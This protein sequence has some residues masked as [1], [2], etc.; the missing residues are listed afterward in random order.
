[1][2]EIMK[3]AETD[4]L[5]LHIQTSHRHYEA[6]KNI[7]AILKYLSE[8]YGVH[9]L[10]LEG[11]WDKLEPELLRLTPEDE[12]TN[13][14]ITDALLKAGEITGAEAFLIDNESPADGW[15]IEDYEAYAANGAVFKEIIRQEPLIEKGLTQVKAAWEKEAAKYFSKQLRDFI[16]REEAFLA[17]Q[18]SM[19]DWLDHLTQ[20]AR[21]CLHLDLENVWH[22]ATWP[23]LVRYARLKKVGELFNEEKIREESE[24]FIIALRRLQISEEIVKSIQ[25][26][27]GSEL[28]Q[29]N[30]AQAR[31]ILRSRTQDGEEIPASAT[32]FL[33]ERLFD[34]LPEDFSMELFPNLKL[35]IQQLVLISELEGEKLEEETLRLTS[36][37]TEALADGERDKE[38]V[39]MLEA[40]RHFE[41]LF[42]LELTRKEYLNAFTSRGEDPFNR[43]WE[44]IFSGQKL[45]AKDKALK[46][47]LQ[48]LYAKAVQFYE[49][50]VRR[51]KWMAEN[52]LSHLRQLENRKAVLITGGFHA[53]GLKDAILNQ[54]VSYVQ[55]TPRVTDIPQNTRE[56]Y[57]QM[58]LGEYLP[59]NSK[60]EAALRL[61]MQDWPGMESDSWPGPSQQNVAR[62]ML[63]I[64]GLQ[65]NG[66]AELDRQLKTSRLAQLAGL[67][68]ERRTV[69][70][71]D[72]NPPNRW[73]GHRWDDWDA[74]HLVQTVQSDTAGNY[75]I[76]ID[77][78]E[79]I[80]RLVRQIQGP[81]QPN[82]RLVVEA[83]K[84]GHALTIEEAV[85][86]SHFSNR[87][88][89]TGTVDL[90]KWRDQIV[91][92]SKDKKGKVKPLSREEAFQILKQIAEIR[93]MNA[94]TR[95]LPMPLLIDA[96]FAFG[97][98]KKLREMLFDV[99][100]DYVP[101]PTG[102][103]ASR[104]GSNQ[105]AAVQMNLS[106][107]I[108][109]AKGEN[110]KV[111][112]WDW[113]FKALDRY[114]EQHRIHVSAARQRKTKS[115]LRLSPTETSTAR[116]SMQPPSGT[117]SSTGV[118]P[119]HEVQVGPSRS[120]PHQFPTEIGTAQSFGPT[121]QRAELREV[122]SA[123]LL[124]AASV[125]VIG[126]DIS[127]RIQLRR[128]V[129][130]IWEGHVK[131]E[132]SDPD[133]F[134]GPGANEMFFVNESRKWTRRLV[135]AI[136]STTHDWKAS[137]VSLDELLSRI[138]QVSVSLI[139]RNRRSGKNEHWYITVPDSVELKRLA[140]DSSRLRSIIISHSEL[141]TE[142]EYFRQL[143]DEHLEGIR[144][145][146]EKFEERL[147]SIAGQHG[148]DKLGL[149]YAV[150]LDVMRYN[151]LF[152]GDILE[153]PGYSGLSRDDRAFLF[154]IILTIWQMVYD[155]IRQLWTE[156]SRESN[157]FERLAQVLDETGEFRAALRVNHQEALN[158]VIHAL[159]NSG[160]V[161]GSGKQTASDWVDYIIASA[162]RFEEGR[163][164]DMNQTRENILLLK[165]LFDAKF[166]YYHQLNRYR[167]KS[168][169]RTGGRVSI[170]AFVEALL[171]HDGEF[172]RA[173]D[174]DDQP[175]RSELR[176]L[177][178]EWGL[179]LGAVVLG[180]VFYA[181]NVYLKRAEFFERVE[182]I[183][184]E[185]IRGVLKE[186]HH[187]VEPGHEDQ[188][189][190]DSWVDR[191][192][193]R[194]LL[195]EL[196]GV[197]RKKFRNDP[198]A[199][200]I[201]NR[202][203]RQ[204]SDY[205][206]PIVMREGDR[207]PLYHFN[208][209]D[210]RQLKIMLEQP[211]RLNEWILN[212]KSNF[213]PDEIE[214]T[215]FQRS[216]LRTGDIVFHAEPSPLLPAIEKFYGQFQQT[217]GWMLEGQLSGV[218]EHRLVRDMLTD[219]AQF[220]QSERKWLRGGDFKKLTSEEEAFL[221]FSYLL[222]LWRIIHQELE[223]V[224][225]EYEKGKQPVS[226]F[227]AYLTQTP[228]EISGR[229]W[230]RHREPFGRAV[231]LIGQH[232][233]I[234]WADDRRLGADFIDRV[235]DRL[236]QS[237]AGVVQ[238]LEQENNRYAAMAI[239]NYLFRSRQ[240][241]YKEFSDY[242][243]DY[244]KKNL[245]S[246]RPRHVNE[247]RNLFYQALEQYEDTL[248]RS[249]LRKGVRSKT[250]V[251]GELRE[252]ETA[253]NGISRALSD[254][255][256]GLD[257]EIAN[258]TLTELN[259]QKDR[260]L[261][262][263]RDLESRS[264]LRHD[265]VLEW[266]MT[267]PNRDFNQ[268][269]T[270]FTFYAARQY[271]DG[272]A[273]LMTSPSMMGIQYKR[274]QSYD[275][276]L[277]RHNPQ[278]N[279]L[280]VVGKTSRIDEP[281]AVLKYVQI[282]FSDEDLRVYQGQAG[283][284]HGEVA[285]GS[286]EETRI[287]AEPLN[288]IRY[289][290][291]RFELVVSPQAFSFLKA[292][293]VMITGLTYVEKT[294]ETEIRP[295]SELHESISPVLGWGGTV[296]ILLGAGLFLVTLGGLAA[297]FLFRRWKANG[298]YD[299][300][301]GVK[302][303]VLAAVK[304]DLRVDFSSGKREM[305]EE[306][307][308]GDVIDIDYD[309][310]FSIDWAALP[311][312]LLQDL[313]RQLAE[314]RRPKI[315]F[316]SGGPH[317]IVNHV[318]HRFSMNRGKR[319]P[320]RVIAK[321]T[322]EIR[323][324]RSELRA[325]SVS[326]RDFFGEAFGDWD[327]LVQ[328]IQRSE[329]TYAAIKP[330][331]HFPE[332]VQL[333]IRY[334][335]IRTFV[336]A[337]FLVHIGRPIRLTREEAEKF[338]TV[339]QGKPFFDA[340]VDYVSSDVYVPLL[341]EKKDG[342]E[343][344]DHAR[345]TIVEIRRKAQ[346][347][348]LVRGAELIPQG[349]ETR[350]Y[351]QNLIH[352]SD[353]PE[354]AIYEVGVILS[355]EGARS[356]MRGMTDHV[357]RT[358]DREN[359]LLTPTL[360]PAGRRQ[361]EGAIHLGHGS[362]DLGLERSE[363]RTPS[364]A[365]WSLAD[366]EFPRG[367]VILTDNYIRS[368]MKTYSLP[369]H[370]K[371]AVLERQ[372]GDHL[373]YAGK[374]VT[375]I[376][377][378]ELVNEVNIISLQTS[379]SV[380]QTLENLL[381][382][383]E[384][385]LV[386]VP[387]SSGWPENEVASWIHDYV[388]VRGSPL[389]VLLYP[390]PLEKNDQFFYTPILEYDFEK[391][392]LPAVKVH[393]TQNRRTQY[394][395]AVRH[396]LRF[397][398][399]RA[400]AERRDGPLS[401]PVA[402]AF[403]VELIRKGE[404]QRVLS[405][406]NQMAELDK[407][408]PLIVISPHPDDDVI[409]A[410]GLIRNILATTGVENW[411]LGRGYTGVTGV[412]DLTPEE[413]AWGMRELQQIFKPG[414]D[415]Y[416]KTGF[417]PDLYGRVLK[418]T[419]ESPS[420]EV[421]SIVEYQVD[422]LG[423][424]PAVQVKINQWELGDNVQPVFGELVKRI[425]RRKEVEE[426]S[427]I[428]SRDLERHVSVRWFD[429]HSV[430][431]PHGL[432]P[433]VPDWMV[434]Q[435]EVVILEE[436]QHFFNEHR[437]QIMASQ[438]HGVPWSIV[439]PHPEDQHPHHK[440]TSQIV[441]TVLQDL[442][443]REG[444]EIQ[445]I[446]YQ[447]PWAGGFDTY[448]VTDTEIPSEA[449][450]P[451]SGL[452]R[453][454]E[455]SAME[456]YQRALTFLVGELAGRSFGLS[457]PTPEQL[458]GRFT[459]SFKRLVFE[460]VRSELRND[461]QKRAGDLLN[462]LEGFDTAVQTAFKAVAKDVQKIDE[463]G[464]RFQVTLGGFLGSL[465][466]VKDLLRAEDLDR[467]VFL[468]AH[469]ALEKIQSGMKELIGGYNPKR[470]SLGEVRTAGNQLDGIIK[471]LAAF[472]GV[473]K[474]P[475]AKT[476]Q[477]KTEP[478][479]E[480]VEGTVTPRESH[481]PSI[482]VKKHQGVDG[483]GAVSAPPAEFFELASGL[484]QSVLSEML[485]DPEINAIGKVKGPAAEL[486][487]VKG[488]IIWV[489]LGSEPETVAKLVINGLR[490]GKED[491]LPV[492]YGFLIVSYRAA[493]G[494]P[495]AKMIV[496]VPETVPA[497][498][499]RS[500]RRV[501][502]E[503]LNR[504]LREHKALD[505]IVVALHHS[506]RVRA[507]WVNAPAGSNVKGYYVFLSQPADWDEGLEERSAPV[508]MY[509][510]TEGEMQQYEWEIQ[511]LMDESWT[512]Q[513]RKGV[514]LPSDYFL[515][516]KKKKKVDLAL[517]SEDVFKKAAKAMA[518]FT[519]HHQI[520]M[521]IRAA[522][523]SELGDF[524]YGAEIKPSQ[525]SDFG[526]PASQAPQNMI[527][528]LQYVKDHQYEILVGVQDIDRSMGRIRLVL[529]GSDEKIGSVEEDVKTDLPGLS[530]QKAKVIKEYPSGGRQVQLGRKVVI[531]RDFHQLN[532][533]YQIL[534]KRFR[535]E[536]WKGDYLVSVAEIERALDQMQGARGKGQGRSE[537][538]DDNQYVARGNGTIRLVPSEGNKAEIHIVQN[539]V[540]QF[541]FEMMS[542]S[543]Q[544]VVDSILSGIGSQAIEAV[545]IGSSGHLMVSVGDFNR[546][547]VDPVLGTVEFKR[548]YV[549][550]ASGVIDL[551]VE[552]RHLDHLA[553]T[554]NGGQ[555]FTH[556]V[557]SAVITLTAIESVKGESGYDAV[558]QDANGNLIIL[559]T[560]GYRVRVDATTDE[561]SAMPATGLD[562]LQPLKEM[563]P[564]Q[565]GTSEWEGEGEQFLVTSRQGEI[566]I[567]TTDSIF[568]V[569]VNLNGK[570]EFGWAFAKPAAQVVDE[571][572]DV[573]AQFGSP[574]G[575][576][577]VW[578]DKRNRDLVIELDDGRMI[579]VKDQSGEIW[580]RRADAGEGTIVLESTGNYGV[581]V[582]LDGNYR[583]E[584]EYQ[585]GARRSAES[586]REHQGTS[587]IASVWSNLD[588]GVHIFYLDDG[589]MLTAD[590]QTSEVTVTGVKTAGEARPADSVL[591]KLPPGAEKVVDNENGF[592]VL[593]VSRYGNILVYAGNRDRAYEIPTAKDTGHAYREVH[594]LQR[595]A[596]ISSIWKNPET[597]DHFIVLSDGRVIQMNYA[598]HEVTFMSADTAP[599]NLPGA[600]KIADSN[601]G[602]IMLSAASTAL[603]LLVNDA[604]KE[605]F[606]IVNPLIVAQTFNSLR[607]GSSIK[608]VWGT[609]EELFF[610]LD[611]KRVIVIV[612][613][614][615]NIYVEGEEPVS[616]SS[617]AVKE[618]PNADKVADWGNG[619]IALRRNILDE[620]MVYEGDRRV[621]IVHIPSSSSEQVWNQIRRLRA[622][623]EIVAVWR[624][625][626]SLD[627]LIDLSDGR[628][629]RI[630]DETGRIGVEGGDAT[631]PAPAALVP[632][633]SSF[634]PQEAVLVVDST[635]GG[636]ALEV[637][638]DGDI[639]IYIGG[640]VD[641][642]RRIDNTTL[643][644]AKEIIEKLGDHTITAIWLK[645]SESNYYLDKAYYFVLDNGQTVVFNGRT[646]EVSI[647]GVG[648][649]PAGADVTAKEHPGS[650]RVADQKNGEI[651]IRWDTDDQLEVLEGRSLAHTIFLHDFVADRVLSQIQGLQGSSRVV[652]VWEEIST[653]DTLIDLSDGR[654]LRINEINSR[655][656]VEGEPVVASA[657]RAGSSQLA[658]ASADEMLEMEQEAID[659]KSKAEPVAFQ[660]T[661]DEI[662]ERGV[663]VVL[664]GE[665]RSEV[666]G[667]IF[668]DQLD[669]DLS[670]YW[671]GNT[672]SPVYLVSYKYR[673]PE[674]QR[675][676]ALFTMRY[677]RALRER[678]SGTRQRMTRP[679]ALEYVQ[680][681]FQNGTTVEAVVLGASSKG[682]GINFMIGGV[683]RAFMRDRYARPRSGE[684]KELH[685]VKVDV[686]SGDD[687]YVEL[688]E[689]DH[690]LRRGR[691]DYRRYMP[692]V[693]QE[694]AMS[695]L[696]D[697][698][699]RGTTVS[700]RAGRPNERRTGL[701]GT[702][703][704]A[705]HVFYRDAQAAA[706]W[707]RQTPEQD[708][709]G[710]YVVQKVE[711]GPDSFYILQRNRPSASGPRSQRSMGRSGSGG[712]FTSSGPAGLSPYRRKGGRTP[713]KSKRPG[714]GGLDGGR[715]RSEL[716]IWKNG[717]LGE[718]QLEIYSTRAHWEGA[719]KMAVPREIILHSGRGE[720]VLLNLKAAG[721]A[722]DQ[723]SH[724]VLTYSMVAANSL[725]SLWEEGLQ[726]G[727]FKV[728]IDQEGRPVSQGI[729][730][731]IFSDVQ[732]Q[733]AYLG[734]S[735][736]QW[737]NAAT[738]GGEFPFTL[739]NSRFVTFLTTNV[740][741]T[742]N[743]LEQP[744]QGND[745]VVDHVS[746]VNYA[747]D[748]VRK[749]AE[750]VLVHSATGGFGARGMTPALAQSIIESETRA[751][752]EVGL[753]VYANV[754]PTRSRGY[755]EDYEKNKGE[756][757]QEML[758]NAGIAENAG[759]DALV[760]APLTFLRSS[761]EITEVVNLLVEATDLPVVFYDNPGL[762]LIPGR[763][764]DAA[765]VESLWRSG[766]IAAIKVSTD[767]FEI[768]EGYLRTGIRVYIGNE[769]LIARAMEKGA[770]GSV[771][772]T[773]NI[774]SLL[775]DLP[776]TRNLD[777]LQ[778]LQR[779]VDDLRGPLTVDQTK[780]TA[781]ILYVLA[782][783]GIVQ[784]VLL[785]GVPTL[786]DTEK[787][788]IDEALVKV[789]RLEAGK[790]AG[791]AQAALEKKVVDRFIEDPLGYVKWLRDEADDATLTLAINHIE[792]VLTVEGN[793]RILEKRGVLEEIETVLDEIF[794]AHEWPE[795]AF[796]VGEGVVDAAQADLQRARQILV[797]QVVRKLSDDRHAEMLNRFY[798]EGV[799]RSL[800]ANVA[801]AMAAVPRHLYASRFNGA[802]AYENDIVYIGR[803]QT[804]SQPSLIA[805][806]LL[807]LHL[808]GDEKVL[809]V[810][811]GSGWLASLLGQ[812]T[813]EVY[814]TEI[815]EL[816]RKRA[817]RTVQKMG[818]QNV[819]ILQARPDVLGYP[820]AGPYDVIVV[821]AGSS[822]ATVPDELANQLA[823]GGKLLIPLLDED[824]Q[825]LRERENAK[826][827]YSLKVFVKRNGVLVDIFDMKAMGYP[828]SFVPL[829]LPER[830]EL[831]AIN[832]KSE[833]SKSANQLVI[834][835]GGKKKSGRHMRTVPRSFTF[836]VWRDAAQLVNEIEAIAAT[837]NRHYTG[838]IINSERGHLV[839]Q[840]SEEATTL[841]TK[842]WHKDG[843]FSDLESGDLVIQLS[844]GASILVS[845]MDNYAME[846]PPA[847]MTREIKMRRRVKL[848]GLVPSILSVSA[849]GV[850]QGNL[851]VERSSS[852]I[853]R[854]IEG[855]I[856]EQF[857][858]GERFFVSAEVSPQEDVLELVLN[859]GQ[860]VVVTEDGKRVTIEE[861]GR[862]A[863]PF[864]LRSVVRLV[865]EWE[866]Y[867]QVQINAS[868]LAAEMGISSDLTVTDRD[869]VR[870]IHL[871]NQSG[872]EY[873]LVDLP[874]EIGSTF[875]ILPRSEY[876]KV[877]PPEDR[878]ELRSVT[879]HA[880]RTMDHGNLSLTP[881]LSPAG[882]ARLPAVGQ[883][884]GASDVV[885]GPWSVVQARS[886]LRRSGHHYETIQGNIWVNREMSEFPD[887]P[888]LSEFVISNGPE[889]NY[890]N[891]DANFR[892]RVLY[893][894]Y[895]RAIVQVKVPGGEWSEEIQLY[896]QTGRHA[897]SGTILMELRGFGK[898]E[899]PEFGF[900][901]P[902]ESRVLRRREFDR[903]VQRRSELR[904]DF[905][906]YVNEG[907]YTPNLKGWLKLGVDGKEGGLYEFSEFVISVE[908][909]LADFDD[910]DRNIR[911]QVTDF[912]KAE[913][914]VEFLWKYP[915]R[916]WSQPV[917]IRMESD[918]FHITRNAIIRFSSFDR[919][920]FPG[921]AFRDIKR[922]HEIL[923]RRAYEEIKTG[924]VV[925]YPGEEIDLKHPENN[926]HLEIADA[927]ADQGRAMIKYHSRGANRWTR[928][929][930]LK[931][932]AII[933]IDGLISVTYRGLDKEGKPQF[934]FEPDNVKVMPGLEYRQ[935]RQSAY[936]RS[937]SKSELRIEIPE[938]VEVIKDLIKET[939]GERQIRITNGI[940]ANRLNISESA[941][942]TLML[943]KAI[944]Q[945][946]E[947]DGTHFLEPI[948]TEIGHTYLVET[949]SELRGEWFNLS[950]D[951]RNGRA[952]ENYSE[953][954]ISTT[955]R[956]DVTDVD[957]NIRVE[958][959]ESDWQREWV[960]IRVKLPGGEWS[961]AITLFRG[962][963]YP[964]TKSVD[965]Q[966]F[967]FNGSRE[968][969]LGVTRLP[970]VGV[971]R[972]RLF[973]RDHRRWLEQQPAVRIRAELRLSPTETNTARASAQSPGGTSSS[974][975]VVPAHE[976]QVTMP[977]SELRSRNW[978]NLPLDV[979]KGNP[980]MGE[981]VLSMPV[982]DM[983]G[984]TM[985][986][987]RVDNN[988]RLQITAFSMKGAWIEFRYKLPG[989]HAKWSKNYR[990]QMGDGLYP[991]TESVE[992]ELGSFTEEG[993]PVI[994][995][996]APRSVRI[997]TRQNYDTSN[998]QKTVW[999]TLRADT[1000]AGNLTED[1001][1002][1003][1004]VINKEGEVDQTD[1005]NNN[1006][1007]VQVIDKDVKKQ[1008]VTITV[1009]Y[1010]GE[1011]KIRT[1012]LLRRHEEYPVF[1013]NFSIRFHYFDDDGTPYFDF[1014]KD[1015]GYKVLRRS[1016]YGRGP[1017]VQHS[1018]L[1019]EKRV[1020]LQG[1021]QGMPELV[1022]SFLPED[1023]QNAV[1024]GYREIGRVGETGIFA[1025][1026]VKVMD[1027]I[1028]PL[1029]LHGLAA[1030]G[1031]FFTELLS[1032]NGL[1033][1034]AAPGQESPV[1035][1036]TQA[1037][1038]QALG[1039]EKRM[1040]D[1041]I[1042][1043]GPDAAF[1044]LAMLPAVRAVYAGVPLF[1045]VGADTRQ[1046]E[1047]LGQFNLD[1048][1049]QSA[1050]AEVRLIDDVSQIR[1051]ELL[1052]KIGD[1053]N[1054][1055]A[1056]SLHLTA[1057]LT[1058]RDSMMLAES[1059]KDQIPNTIF[1060]T[1061]RMAEHFRAQAGAYV[1062]SLVAEFQA[1063]Y[1064]VT[1065]SA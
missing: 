473:T 604:V 451:D 877:V 38:L 698:L 166:H 961:E 463:E 41:K 674:H 927:D 367:G 327:N 958:V 724:N 669:Q 711:K 88:N 148:I 131:R 995:F 153:G 996:F 61:Q 696:E 307:M 399:A 771:G 557:K 883:G 726:V 68:S 8:R 205:T 164:G 740:L 835:V 728:E 457:S 964:L 272:S 967:T 125:F 44:E 825:A 84:S 767:Q 973:N 678:Q 363:S 908:G 129:T 553:V 460:P 488:S 50:A 653:L 254:P 710:L 528:L 428:L 5:I 580:V 199:I 946:N 142:D 922:K 441:M 938:I 368:D 826:R 704:G 983:P 589:R 842:G 715:R 584:L 643:S 739:Q 193:S 993:I 1017:V 847:G 499:P 848:N 855:L 658:A 151:T 347:S 311:T 844:D 849:E 353:S 54:G 697:A 417:V 89:G 907:Q 516:R 239:L 1060:V 1018:E 62:H 1014:T 487:K 1042:V 634:I 861:G 378:A 622:S 184:V 846:I 158:L 349:V 984:S 936:R 882:R 357:Q 1005:I 485:L 565:T 258:R 336:Q 587:R 270:D 796:Q 113:G 436:F 343:I 262:E 267:D 37:I 917:K 354:N 96:F 426:A 916:G 93:L 920:G 218:K 431:F 567:E 465:E 569:A 285:S 208:L 997:F 662:R 138:P 85:E 827:L 289:Q 402:N 628:T 156:L 226:G 921:F 680:D 811:G 513:E 181:L 738:N 1007:R 1002:S 139:R 381:S 332:E 49:G 977:R 127:W 618:H 881:T 699:Q 978:V 550:A 36:W 633:A 338:Y 788:A 843:I 902:G 579:R 333:A 241:F 865:E 854:E 362:W 554:V 959:V 519:S 694:T 522:V 750:A 717:A 282:V 171:R 19:S 575:Y 222:P 918:E 570:S 211:A 496:L 871:Y 361:G 122:S 109:A 530:F 706:E 518:L 605:T 331:G 245:R 309:D 39:R 974:T 931:T 104:R 1026:A 806:I 481:R 174:R 1030:A 70:S 175:P 413:I 755:E 438:T 219:M 1049:R 369:H 731:E 671:W 111:I 45:K 539:D 372:E 792:G 319:L 474:K 443:R 188:I 899:R 971:L 681:A 511:H 167:D 617:T 477:P 850:V 13:L 253:I 940:V 998:R 795:E 220:H 919:E 236:V 529:G 65:L 506:Y 900:Y 213:A 250:T 1033:A 380:R 186:S 1064:R 306:K 987:S 520:V 911:I 379:G 914:W 562:E 484:K 723:P 666:K 702:Y 944:G 382:G 281:D 791:I 95:L 246:L 126:L 654:T 559:L 912:S 235:I 190:D 263:L 514:Y 80:L 756:A 64:A 259:T 12:E 665:D 291:G 295:R 1046:K 305:T 101:E 950:V 689:T 1041:A 705:V 264:E 1012:V 664:R 10:F 144:G 303:H 430:A 906:P 556:T 1048:L 833:T 18:I 73:Q 794:A 1020:A 165:A 163:V 807:F 789:N 455:L 655:V 97:S 154:G 325:G 74:D 745:L 1035:V 543:A 1024:Y 682:T 376:Q 92:R 1059:L 212:A 949:R 727:N 445:L 1065:T 55:I 969:R 31:G 962:D 858:T 435:D 615:G 22:Q 24:D 9:Q 968:P 819:H 783:E 508:Q 744:D 168:I 888:E 301:P 147:D 1029:S 822:R 956:V 273:R 48:A 703:R 578:G 15:G 348:E 780:I 458:G 108:E 342:P 691:S 76:T 415:F 752:K 612:R 183:W 758:Q 610:N 320:S 1019:R 1061:E 933:K 323:S 766:Q 214:A 114:Y 197:L 897:I 532:A 988:I 926:L 548:N 268:M 373:P 192:E 284:E 898:F 288:G 66:D 243:A 52:T 1040:V 687:V 586:L 286:S 784:N 972:R 27:L 229:I 563:G 808:K 493:P 657:A 627:C 419:P 651:T 355:T 275:S 59:S 86:M 359:L 502:V 677:D 121:A 483:F 215:R 1003:G 832:I 761:E 992:F 416:D 173:I 339:H 636:I 237:T 393:H 836:P 1009:A 298:R 274:E 449:V 107:L 195:M 652:A 276:V 177:G 574:I 185:S 692:E 504:H 743:P 385:D 640:Q 118:V 830:A 632:P 26:T 870:A 400:N 58:V 621:S 708:I 572:N 1050:Q 1052:K 448:F 859:D 446:E 753:T 751:M 599:G 1:M 531:L 763:D 115:E 56:L 389:E 928:P 388:Q 478:P 869:V 935:I 279:E 558:W 909:E 467:K 663:D 630:E 146:Y 105:K 100:F 479:T 424:L 947:S 337:G 350:V 405:N 594:R 876:E 564:S 224:F 661:V 316:V 736:S 772:S 152:Y 233:A 619:V 804:I 774:L 624:E 668:A 366:P 90:D 198:K 432:A 894:D 176:T 781:A 63:D 123:W 793:R 716:R 538:R 943:E 905:V 232:A 679:E 418:E 886:E 1044:Q 776:V 257:E 639:D 981:F 395:P 954:V 802:N 1053:R 685:V 994:G 398:A 749:Q 442:S 646:G 817:E 693:D 204:I 260:L 593:E 860:K 510:A 601:D 330:L 132:L 852:E 392:I 713:K 505:G 534:V 476:V 1028:L 135:K 145:V 561:V 831:R 79:E 377:Q 159:E 60:Y 892:V 269:L 507:K 821:S 1036:H 290:S 356:E 757:I 404:V 407:L 787:Q 247:N 53:E 1062:E 408:V 209:P 387:V 737:I 386:L 358:T 864:L 33:F 433:R 889:I 544:T 401:T 110:P 975:G 815:I 420:Q 492:K 583:A 577:A 119:A 600:T 77:E 304:A 500:E 963:T 169:S 231:Q 801:E 468:D 546:F 608:S 670:R 684:V 982:L 585:H 335:I 341:L 1004:F 437:Q 840:L 40:I 1043:L 216:E 512:A 1025:F 838:V 495:E 930:D 1021:A 779:I 383:F 515:S 660:V 194:R 67:R 223:Q 641:R 475:A 623:T 136:Y 690:Q 901:V 777:N 588:T 841:G 143:V 820:D 452:D 712:L 893:W 160:F 453:S 1023:A 765:V 261:E 466:R 790:N 625:Q 576:K 409:A 329:I 533:L 221:F 747:D 397:L 469:A 673:K 450:S 117:S 809:E 81:E 903:G 134:K 595:G 960:T 700:I 422:L 1051:A 675:K 201:L 202:I 748:L 603:G 714:R 891:V 292:Q 812:L 525:Q 537:L 1038:Q 887:K 729:R 20:E 549:S 707:S 803:R 925:S 937:P 244:A 851:L 999:F 280:V 345:E 989:R 805:M 340:L 120:E 440:T 542:G 225:L 99:A 252:V 326:P 251:Q 480:K 179:A 948:R 300:Y 979:E 1016:V 124:A 1031:P 613:E 521:D 581:T 364:S 396:L 683:L 482:E 1045:V 552:R 256:D 360:S 249:E 853:I 277:I 778:Y 635:E 32:R 302:S 551:K 769:G 597:W 770:I 370:R 271:H 800:L 709:D 650:S 7:Q 503:E 459:E 394:V 718:D 344:I 283:E 464:S 1055:Q 642:D 312:P 315:E 16:R 328:R 313:Y 764:I 895:Q 57:L 526:P 547:V 609:S 314:Q 759:A 904:D 43:L 945:F 206:E 799:W 980:E 976:V 1032:L 762:H 785:P 472:L 1015:T 28:N 873:V 955:G 228:R 816:L 719:E 439:V 255:E 573:R 29:G 1027:G 293:E 818:I 489:E 672:I 509:L 447:S 735:L 648:A 1037:A 130:Q 606:F 266:P 616:S 874:T 384:P 1039:F 856:G 102:K 773:G 725:P 524:Q 951:L 462:A 308:G 1013:L 203:A 498:S 645:K 986:Y 582:L 501:K 140:E 754:T 810:G 701:N 568:T 497:E 94:D 187:P 797:E 941:V 656:T 1010:P 837:G 106:G 425:I 614:N 798:E 23:I 991:I 760:L 98:V 444:I 414:G 83:W 297:V 352:G 629:I 626:T 456:Q 829:I 910:L 924:L 1034:M 734:E 196:A 839:T 47:G 296:S 486:E 112:D 189:Q 240:L 161:T 390:V 471:E 248:L 942:T 322:F 230:Q 1047:L 590:N 287:I 890:A 637:T 461:F 346:A 965:I 857:W 423:H 695:E 217:I 429:L 566:T 775:Q 150:L 494:S 137:L 644:K 371:I 647:E 598:T 560:N 555:F 87:M 4:S 375:A 294:S 133:Y 149:R 866:D 42:S 34:V 1022:E 863:D 128:R 722:E 17:N 638:L 607:R 321:K 234:R 162:A 721:R 141:R 527:K 896:M 51:E 3:S 1063:R 14:R 688:G 970:H 742:I 868:V 180:G 427:R 932:D 1056:S 172:L 72:L 75:E 923:R 491:K 421:R 71:E 732:D 78:A 46:E 952:L 536:W 238:S 21:T 470:A 884:E 880:E 746:L 540:R 813:E 872:S 391:I 878:S 611:D 1008:T 25:E 814:S 200:E 834:E 957:R 374:F 207:T 953:L 2:T 875:Q 786:E 170:S 210:P 30:R 1000:W 517:K 1058:A 535:P 782:K 310:E 299:N 885:R 649:A 571:I 915:G 69:R 824:A 879:D 966:L 631:T 82:P 541:T 591:S 91:Q 410:G 35:F 768:V 676:S 592:I 324:P 318:E 1001:L 434:Q 1057:L 913:K 596:D 602:E 1006:V 545:W 103:T 334:Q 985:D 828:V 929:R 620:I 6:Q 178:W 351:T 939:D 182:Q 862:I 406:R 720:F 191:H 116:D 454:E 990:L 730:I 317:V 242:V 523:F 1054:M 741:P 227:Y 823:E 11:G 490:S 934:E 412:G 157:P 686:Q 733:Y 659:A 867:G 403:A 667:F 845:G 278:E 411:V 365:H 1011:Q 155:E 265:P